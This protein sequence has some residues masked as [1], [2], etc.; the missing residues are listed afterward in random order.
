LVEDLVDVLVFGGARVGVEQ[1]HQ[2]T[3]TVLEIV[4][5]A[6]DVVANFF[7]RPRRLADGGL[8]A[9]DDGSVPAAEV[10]GERS[11]AVCLFRS[12]EPPA[13][14]LEGWP[15]KRNVLHSAGMRYA[16]RRSD[17]AGVW[18]TLH[19]DRTRPAARRV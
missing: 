1:R 8:D 11:E 15:G 6:R 5:L 10:G 9:F 19:V 7:R 12:H 17:E 3:K 16:A 2:M 18:D 14:C 4:F 13:S